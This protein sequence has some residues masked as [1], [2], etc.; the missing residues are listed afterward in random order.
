MASIVEV[1]IS[2]LDELEEKLEHL[3]IKVSRTIIR[4]SLKEAAQ[5]FLDEMK[6]RVRR[7]VHHFK[8]SQDAFAVI[9]KSIGMRL[10]VTSDLEGSATVGV[11][12]SVFWAKFVEFG[13]K[14]RFRGK[15]SGGKRSGGPTGTMPSYPFVR[16]AFEAKKQEVLDKFVTDVK[17]ALNEAGLKLQ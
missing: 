6:A 1:K 14:A 17:Q 5:I 13:T 4:R 3:P 7:G 10:R 11:P 2:G 9:Q 12:K 16:P 15:K 8:G